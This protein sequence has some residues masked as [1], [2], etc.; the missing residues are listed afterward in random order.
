[1]LGND[2]MLYSLMSLQLNTLQLTAMKF[3][4]ASSKSNIAKD[5]MSTTGKIHQDFGLKRHAEGVKYFRDLNFKLKV[6]N[7]YKYK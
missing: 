1:M 2:S 5:L 7:I 3:K 6:I 4:L